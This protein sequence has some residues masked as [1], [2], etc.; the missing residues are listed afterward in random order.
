VGAKS[1]GQY[2]RDVVA[3][4]TDADFWVGLPD[5]EHKRVA[6]VFRERPADGPSQP[7]PTLGAQGD[8][9]AQR[10]GL[11]GI[12]KYSAS[13]GSP[14]WKRAE[15]PALNGHGNARGMARIYSP[16]A[17]GGS[18]N[19]VTLMSPESVKR[20]SQTIAA[21]M[22]R[23][24]LTPMVRSLGFAKPSDSADPRPRE[25]FGHGGMGGSL[26]YA[27]PV[28]RLSFGYAMN[29]MSVAG[30]RPDTRAD[31]LAAAA[32]ASLKAK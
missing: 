14:E 2:F 23:N 29:M 11:L 8:E 32:Y 13:P 18:I 17:N 26:G 3:K 16:M 12:E 7:A 6:R 28:N 30:G 20:A 5:S 27:D 19:G 4:P 10:I 31:D 15:M 21:G 22:D 1:F 9:I 25:A 24:T